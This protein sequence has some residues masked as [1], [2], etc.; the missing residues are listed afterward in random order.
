MG[1]ENNLF[2]SDQS[3]TQLNEIIEKKGE[4]SDYERTK[5]AQFNSVVSS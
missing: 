4:D 5:T 2:A 1:H 3:S